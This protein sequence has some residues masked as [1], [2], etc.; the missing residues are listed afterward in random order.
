MTLIL[1]SSAADEAIRELEDQSLPG[2][3]RYEYGVIGLDVYTDLSVDCTYTV[4]REGIFG[5][6]DLFC[7]R[8]GSLGP[9]A[10]D[11]VINQDGKGQVAYGRLKYLGS[12]NTAAA[13]MPTPTM[14]LIEQSQSRYVTVIGDAVETGAVGTA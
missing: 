8:G 7:E 10:A 14:T 12:T 13:A 2:L 3:W 4:L 9:V 5:L 11:F 6:T 1:A